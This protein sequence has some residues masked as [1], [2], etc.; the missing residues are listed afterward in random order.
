C[1]T[2]FHFPGFA[3]QCC[4]GTCTLI[5]DLMD[6]IQIDEWRCQSS[7][8]IP[9]TI[10]TACS[11]QCHILRQTTQVLTDVP[12]YPA[13]GFSRLDWIRSTM[14]QLIR[15]I[16]LTVYVRRTDTDNRILIT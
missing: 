16:E 5:T 6:I 1:K 7:D 9:F 11:N 3:D 14:D 8:C 12:R 4:I 2:V 13:N 15:Y 10:H